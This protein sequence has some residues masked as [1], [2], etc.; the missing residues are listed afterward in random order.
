MT[1]LNDTRQALPRIPLFGRWTLEAYLT[2]ISIVGIGVHAAVLF[3]VGAGLL[4]LLSPELTVL[5]AFIFLGELLTI[6]APR[7]DKITSSASFVYAL[8]IMFGAPAAM[9]VQA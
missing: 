9:L 6:K 2:V 8:M 4:D 7:H 5:V 1:P 3:D